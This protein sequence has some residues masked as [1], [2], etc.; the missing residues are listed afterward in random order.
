MSDIAYELET[1]EQENFDDNVRDRQRIGRRLYR[2]LRRMRRTGGYWWD[3]FESWSPLPSLQSVSC[4]ASAFG[5]PDEKS[6]YLMLQQLPP[7]NASLDVT[8]PVTKS[9]GPQSR[10][11]HLCR[12]TMMADPLLTTCQVAAWPPSKL[13]VR[14]A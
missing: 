8:S 10:G 14:S 5:K 7:G 6:C 13:T 9:A 2:A 12:N 3:S 1:R 4:N 11:S